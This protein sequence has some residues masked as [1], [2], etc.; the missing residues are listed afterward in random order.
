MSAINSQQRCHRAALY[1]IYIV[2]YE[3]KGAPTLVVRS[4]RKP[5][6]RV[7]GSAW[8]SWTASFRRAKLILAIIEPRDTDLTHCTR[9]RNTRNLD[10]FF[11]FLSFTATSHELTFFVTFFLQI[12]ITFFQSLLVSGKRS[13]GISS[14][15]TNFPDIKLRVSIRKCR[16]KR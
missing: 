6:K 10:R 4:A 16:R 5:R 12:I 7:G 3:D 8:R 2:N 9:L 11:V 1:A 13:I 15:R 14:T